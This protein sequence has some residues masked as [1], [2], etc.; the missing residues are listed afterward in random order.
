MPDLGRLIDSWGYVAVFLIVVLGNLGLPVPEETVLTIGGYLAWQGRLKWATVVIVAIVGAVVG[1]NM[2]YWLGR[3]YGQRLLNRVAAAAPERIERARQ[4][5]VRHGMLAV[6]AARFV[7]GLRFMAGPLAGSTGL[8]PARFFIA[9]LLGAVLYVP[10]MV[11]VGYGV[12]YGLG[13]RIESLRRAAGN[14]ERIAVA[15]L[16]LVAISV[17]LVRARRARRAP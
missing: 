14:T 13:E 1:D 4:F 2:S 9:N 16:A 12:G 10:V 17:W 5:V 7:A 11:G 6:F 8:E 15:V 3:R